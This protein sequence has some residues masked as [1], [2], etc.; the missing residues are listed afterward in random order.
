MEVREVIVALNFA[1]SVVDEARLLAEVAEELE[2]RCSLAMAVEEVE[3][4]ARCSLHSRKAFVMRAVGLVASCLWEA[5]R[6]LVW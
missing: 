1:L 3:D 4:V 5:A 6:A 2:G